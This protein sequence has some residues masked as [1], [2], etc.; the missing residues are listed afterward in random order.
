MEFKCYSN[1]QVVENFEL[2][3]KLKNIAF[4]HDRVYMLS[5]MSEDGFV[6]CYFDNN[7]L[8][9]FTL[10]DIYKDCRNEEF[11][12]IVWFVIDKGR[13]N[14]INSRCFFDNVLNYIKS[15]GVSSVKFLCDDNAW[16]KISDKE[17]LLRKFGYNAYN[18]NDNLYDV[19]IEL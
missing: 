8:V 18:E 7:D 14:I 12:E 11:A 17:K 16:G 10:L 9:G 13:S 3:E 6:I 1:S 2:Y 15:L 19:S 5:L 4:T